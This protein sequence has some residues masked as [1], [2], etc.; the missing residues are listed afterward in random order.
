VRVLV[1]VAML[2]VLTFPDAV[3][4]DGA[5][6]GTF[7]LAVKVFPFDGHWGSVASNLPAIACPQAC[8]ARFP[9]ETAVELLVWTNDTDPALEVSTTWGPPC[10]KA[11][12]TCTVFMDRNRTVEVSFSVS[13]RKGDP[14]LEPLA[15]SARARG[16]GARR[17]IGVTARTDEPGRVAIALLR[18]RRVAKTWSR[19][20]AHRD[21][22][23]LAVPAALRAGAYRLRMGIGFGP[24]RVTAEHPLRLRC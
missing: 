4:A 12:R 20:L 2:V 21:T 23:A 18:G 16:C 24:D 14:I 8:T 6:E 22:F 13:H 9:A 1:T 10:E 17:R 7:E 11:G 3:S 5:Q 19:R 15:F